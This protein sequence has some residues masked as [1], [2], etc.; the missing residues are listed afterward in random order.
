MKKERRET[1]G[2]NALWLVMNPSGSSFGPGANRLA[3]L[4]ED[5]IVDPGFNFTLFPYDWIFPPKALILDLE[6]ASLASVSG[7]LRVYGADTL[8]HTV[9]LGEPG[10]DAW[11]RLLS[12]IHRS[13]PMLRGALL[14][15]RRDWVLAAFDRSAVVHAVDRAET[16]EP[17]WSA[18]FELLSGV[19]TILLDDSP[20]A[21]AFV[22]HYFSLIA[23]Q[24][25]GRQ[26]GG[27]FFDVQ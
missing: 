19:E 26:S 9:V 22:K 12:P 14:P 13:F 20:G 24:P 3:A 1:L 15:R 4:I 25:G 7:D 2:L 27:L 5:H 18:P 11:S 16:D 10:F 21:T 8:A 23:E 6:A 17:D